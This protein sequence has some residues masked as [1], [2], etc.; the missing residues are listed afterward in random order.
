MIKEN[1][2]QKKIV[3]RNGKFEYATVETVIYKHCKDAINAF[4]KKCVSGLYWTKNN[5]DYEDYVQAARM[6]II[7]MFDVYDEVH[8]FSSMVNT[9][10][11][12]LYIYLLRY[13][14]SKKRAMNNMYD[15]DVIAYNEVRLNEHYCN[16]NSNSTSSLNY[17]D[18]IGFEDEHMKKSNVHLAIKEVYKALND[19]DKKIL[20]FLIE[21][22]KTKFEFATE[23][24][25]S[26]PTL[27]KR[28]NNIRDLLKKYLQI[29]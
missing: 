2:P 26:R 8:S 18:V 27:D 6:E 17:E 25:L 9:R 7:T 19:K 3:M 20:D 11:D 12:Q 1:M 23:I 16:G 13:Y 22:S 21:E 14:G 28:I 15:E 29:A 4:A 24:G 10:L 5:F